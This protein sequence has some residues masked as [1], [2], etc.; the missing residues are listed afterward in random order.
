MTDSQMLRGVSEQLLDSTVLY[1][2]PVRRLGFEVK[3]GESMVSNTSLL[4]GSC[5]I[6]L[7]LCTLRDQVDFRW[8]PLLGISHAAY[9][10]RTSL[11]VGADG[12]ENFDG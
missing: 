1:F 6:G 9:L 7:A 5:G 4:F 12:R 10:K 3:L 8:L 2:D 11:K